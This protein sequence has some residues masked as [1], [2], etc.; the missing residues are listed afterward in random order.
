MRRLTVTTY[1]VDDNGDPAWFGPDDEVP[2]WAAAQIDD[3]AAWNEPDSE[4]S[5]GGPESLYKSW[6]KPRLEEEIANRNS[7]RDDEDLIVVAGPGNK[8]DLIAALEDDDERGD[9]PVAP[10]QD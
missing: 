4:T 8:P 3:P 10:E 1:V 6:R 7:G 5:D 9:E 2:D